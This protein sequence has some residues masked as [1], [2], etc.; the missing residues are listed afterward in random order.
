MGPTG[1]DVGVSICVRTETKQG[2]LHFD[3]CSHLWIGLIVRV[4]LVWFVKG[5]HIIFGQAFSEEVVYEEEEV[6]L[7]K[8]LQLMQP[9]FYELVPIWVVDHH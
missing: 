1:N 7:D 2:F 8:P 6:W 4:V 5:I 3:Y 9:Y